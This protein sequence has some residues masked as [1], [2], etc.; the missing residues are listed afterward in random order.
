MKWNHKGILICAI[1]FLAL[2]GVLAGRVYFSRSPEKS[3]GVTYA[4]E[5]DVIAPSSASGAGITNAD[6]KAE[7]KQTKMQVPT[8]TA[9]FT[10]TSP[11]TPTTVPSSENQTRKSEKK[12]AKTAKGK[13][14]KTKKN[15]ERPTT[16]PVA[17][18]TMTAV[19]TV[20]PE[21]ATVSFDIQCTAVIN[22]RELW[23]DGLEEI[24]PASGYFYRGHQE[25]AEGDTVYDVL[26]RVCNKKNIALDAEFTPL[27][28]SY[29]IKGIGN[30][31][32]FD[33][34]SESGWK[35]KV[36]DKYADV[37][38]SSY[39]LKKGDHVVFVYDYQL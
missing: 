1:G 24:I 18:P 38:C 4:S 31:Y 13:K 23:R 19:P 11:A 26:K 2:I 12:A 34:G 16:Q 21:A 17:K 37:S 6:E 30:L 15:P 33:C 10:A 25:I 27:F 8:A 22:H 5:E 14:T 7:G 35:Y 9:T 29:Y 20:S 36:N 32:E 28:G 3:E 39:P